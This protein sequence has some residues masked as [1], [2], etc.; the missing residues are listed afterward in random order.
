MKAEHW[1]T[2][3]QSNQ[4]TRTL[5]KVKRLNFPLNSEQNSSRGKSNELFRA[6][7]SAECLKLYLAS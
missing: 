6:F 4:Y 7:H 1:S 2:K 3:S 5:S